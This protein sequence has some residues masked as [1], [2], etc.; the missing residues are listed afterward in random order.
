MSRNAINEAPETLYKKI[1][2]S[3]IHSKNAFSK[4]AVPCSGFVRLQSSRSVIKNLM[5]YKTHN[6]R[7]ILIVK[8]SII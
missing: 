3:R 6:S 8:V 4:F 1:M 7:P 5:F 2:C